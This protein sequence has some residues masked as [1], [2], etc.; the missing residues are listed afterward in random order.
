[1]TLILSPSPPSKQA[2]IIFCKNITR[3]PRIPSRASNTSFLSVN[4][5]HS[6]GTIKAQHFQA[7][8][9]NATAH[10]AASANTLIKSN[11]STSS[12]SRSRRRARS[13]SPAPSAAV[14]AIPVDTE[15]DPILKESLLVHD[16]IIC[17][18]FKD[19]DILKITSISNGIYELSEMSEIHRDLFTSCLS[20]M[21]PTERLRVCEGDSGDYKS[22]PFLS[23]SN[24]FCSYD[25][26]CDSISLDMEKL[27]SKKIKQ[28]NNMDED[29]SSYLKRKCAMLGRNLRNSFQDC[30]TCGNY[31]FDLKNVKDTNVK[32]D[33]KTIVTRADLFSFEEETVATEGINLQRSPTP[34]RNNQAQDEQPVRA[35]EEESFVGASHKSLVTV[36]I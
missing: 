13:R 10:S 16:I 3:P 19:K 33:D 5:T 26:S 18:I 23:Q 20:N 2:E 22:R 21:L 32:S 8:D 35:T 28:L 31:C 14:A 25:M 12:K 7:L 27:T 29:T 36:D 30:F 9:L 4:S 15:P 17:E 1:M 24:S 6:T 11:R 34:K